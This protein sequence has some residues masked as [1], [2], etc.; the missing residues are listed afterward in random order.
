MNLSKNRYRDC[1]RIWRKKGMRAFAHWLRFYN[2]VD[3]KPYL[4][5]M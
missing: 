2:N 4:E 3:D 1:Q 5:A